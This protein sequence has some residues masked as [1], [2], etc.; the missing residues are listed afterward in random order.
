MSG[1]FA[2]I[3]EHLRSATFRELVI[4][5]AG[6]I[7]GRTFNEVAALRERLLNLAFRQ[8]GVPF[9]DRSTAAAWARALD[10]ALVIMLEEAP[11]TLTAYVAARTSSKDHVA[12][13]GYGSIG[14]LAITD[15]TSVVERVWPTSQMTPITSALE[16]SL[17]EHLL[18]VAFG[19]DSFE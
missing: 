8:E 6:G 3:E 12:K 17:H 14:W 9:P 15:P 11:E 4:L 7:D 2:A 16:R 19:L 18:E 5:A 13:Y 1:S 10:S